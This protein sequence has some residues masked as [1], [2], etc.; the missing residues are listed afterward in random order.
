[1]LLGASLSWILV[2]IMTLFQRRTPPELMGRTD[3]ALGIAYA[4]P[5]TIAIAL[6]AGL[7]AVLNYRIL[8]LVIAGLMTLAA[9]YLFTRHEQRRATAA[10]APDSAPAPGGPESAVVPQPGG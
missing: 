3:A 4:V 10:K 9:A 7:I 5:Q 1:M 2:G 8:L 6:G